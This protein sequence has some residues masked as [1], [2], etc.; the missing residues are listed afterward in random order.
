MPVLRGAGWLSSHSGFYMY[1]ER[2]HQEFHIKTYIGSRFSYRFQDVK[3]VVFLNTDSIYYFKSI[4]QE[5]QV[6]LPTANQRHTVQ[7]LTY[8]I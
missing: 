8:R 7:D 1:E 4:E 2:H 3:Q 5:T 6:P